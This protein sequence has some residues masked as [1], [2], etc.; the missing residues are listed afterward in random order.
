MTK[1]DIL[2]MRKG[3]KA[4]IWLYAHW[5]DGTQYVGTTGKTLYQ[6]RDDVDNGKCDKWFPTTEAGLL[7][8]RGQQEALDETH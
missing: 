3:A 7:G 5:K 1:R 8:T 2:L 4:G 6:A